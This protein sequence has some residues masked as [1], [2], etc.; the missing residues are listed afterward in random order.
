MLKKQIKHVNFAFQSTTSTFYNFTAP[1]QMV[2]FYP[3]ITPNGISLILNWLDRTKMARTKQTARRYEAH[4]AKIYRPKPTPARLL[5]SDWKRNKQAY[6]I[7]NID[8]PDYAI[9]NPPPNKLPR[10]AAAGGK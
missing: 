2:C 3:T 8:G 7:A 1:E 5:I 4:K 9:A 10:N 6:D